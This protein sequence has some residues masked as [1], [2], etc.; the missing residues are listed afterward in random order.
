MEKEDSIL[1][2]MICH[3]PIGMK[4]S[5]YIWEDPADDRCAIVVHQH[6]IL[7]RFSKTLERC[8]G[9]ILFCPEDLDNAD[10]LRLKPKTEKE[11]KDEYLKKL[12]GI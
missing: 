3:K 11:K 1:E 5:A 12:L 10:D 4:Q 9:A 7:Q 6:C 2:C 8:C